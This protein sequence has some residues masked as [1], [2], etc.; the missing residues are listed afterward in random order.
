MSTTLPRPGR[1]LVMGVLNVTP[2]SFSD[3]G[4]FLDVGAAVAHAESLGAT[5]AD[6]ERGRYYVVMRDPAHHDA[7]DRGTM[8]SCGRLWTSTQMPVL[9]WSGSDAIRDSGCRRR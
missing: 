1:C 8:A 6:R 5:V 2:D 9:R 7:A 4:Q 3:A